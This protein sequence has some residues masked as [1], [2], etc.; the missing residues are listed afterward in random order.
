MNTLM[1]TIS[2]G[3]GHNAAAEAISEYILKNEPD[4]R[5]KIVDTLKY[6]SPILDKVVI[7]TYLNSLKIYP[8]GFS[9]LYSVFNRKDESVTAFAEKFDE[10]LA[11]RLLPLIVETQPDVIISTH[12]FTTQMLSALKT[13]GHLNLPALAIITDYGSHAL[14]V[15]PG[16]DF[17]V[18]AH[19][20][21]VEELTKTGRDRRTVFPYGIPFRSTF[22]IPY[23]RSQTLSGIGLDEQLPTVTLMGGSLAL[24]HIKTILK[25]LDSIPRQFNIVVVAAN[26]QK[27][28]DEALEIS[29]K[30][31]KNIAVLK[32]CH[33]MDALLQATDLLVTKP[34][35]LTVT[36]ALIT[37]T[38]MAIFKAIGGQEEQNKHFLLKNQ[39]AID[40]GDGEDSAGQ[41]EALLF[42]PHKLEDMTDRIRAFAKP[43]STKKIYGLLRLMVDDFHRQNKTAVPNADT[44]EDEGFNEKLKGL[45]DDAK[46][47]LESNKM[48]SRLME[49]LR[50]RSKEVSDED[51]Y[52]LSDE[53]ISQL[54]D[55][56]QEKH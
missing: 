43:D 2:A 37:G 30:S 55:E 14:W 23:D 54:L 9:M 34:G 10:L 8:K 52:E 42:H 24:G 28:Y 3:H 53:E 16:I 6:I 51:F 26:N 45:F 46:T 22:L 39:L 12:P 35:G 15:H 1:L 44:L 20:S 7:G 36:E 33:F 25:E 21:V 4:S 56:T 19:E 5:I 38:P 50:R 11:D 27:L 31:D 47:R 13:S 18:V 48:T 29:L 40:L 41:I 32:F 49:F 17:Y